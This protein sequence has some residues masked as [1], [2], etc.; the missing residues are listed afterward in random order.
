MGWSVE[1]CFVAKCLLEYKYTCKEWDTMVATVI[2]RNTEFPFLS[3][4]LTI[5]ERD[6]VIGLKKN[7]KKM[8]E[9][10]QINLGSHKDYF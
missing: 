4:N 6:I 2:V 5:V 1:I 3:Q 7:S 9:K 10:F 8:L